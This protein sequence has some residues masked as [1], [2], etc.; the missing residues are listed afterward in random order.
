[1]STPATVALALLV[2]ALGAPVVAQAFSSGVDRVGVDDIDNALHRISVTESRGVRFHSSQDG[3][4]QFILNARFDASEV[5]LHCGWDDVLMVRS[6]YGVLEHGAL[7]RGERAYTR[8][9]WRARRIVEAEEVILKPGDLV[10][11]PAGVAHAVHP[12]GDAPVIYL[13]VKNRS[14]RPSTAGL[15]GA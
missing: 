5:E 4:A 1:M 9:E 15:C 2:T 10:R 8:G 7:V 14:A 13:V 6:G 12:L 11:V 3:N